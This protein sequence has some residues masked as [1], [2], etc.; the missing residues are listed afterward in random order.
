MDTVG[1]VKTNGQSIATSKIVDQTVEIQTIGGGVG[2]VG[3]A[4]YLISTDTWSVSDNTIEATISGQV[5]ICSEDN[6][7][8]FNGLVTL[9]GHAL[10][11]IGDPLYVSTSG[12]ITSTKPDVDNVFLKKIGYIEDADTIRVRIDENYYKLGTE[13]AVSNAR[14]DYGS[15]TVSETLNGTDF[16][17]HTATITES[18]NLIIAGLTSAR[19]SILFEFVV[20][21]SGAGAPIILLTGSPIYKFM[22]DLNLTDL[23]DGT[24][25]AVFNSLDDNVNV[26]VYV[27][28]AP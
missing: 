15:I 14:K 21:D 28:L 9:V 4:Y 27:K 11:A 10:G 23:V 2:V 22:T 3:K 5:G 24:Y 6:V 17:E 12:D 16:T 25:Q 13:L 8:M 1:I 20:A 26:R 19:P 7:I 18:M